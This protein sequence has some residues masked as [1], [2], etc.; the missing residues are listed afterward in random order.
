MSGQLIAALII[1]GCAAAFVLYSLIRSLTGKKGCGSGCG[2]CGGSQEESK[3]SG[4]IS[5]KQVSEK[6]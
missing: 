4:L 1:I 5:L 2:R 6:K 3:R